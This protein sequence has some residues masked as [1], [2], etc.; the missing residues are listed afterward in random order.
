[1]IIYTVTSLLKMTMLRNTLFVWASVW[2]FACTILLSACDSQHTETYVVSDASPDLVLINKNHVITSNPERYQ[3]SYNLDGHLMPSDYHS[4]LS[5]Y[6][7]YDLKVLVKKGDWVEKG[8]PMMTMQA[9]LPI[10]E[11]QYRYYDNIGIE[12]V[13]SHHS[14]STTTS[15]SLVPSYPKDAQSEN[16]ESVVS[17]IENEVEDVADA[18]SEISEDILVES[19][20]AN[21]DS[22]NAQA[23]SDAK[24][25][26]NLSDDD[27]LRSKKDE[28]DNKDKANDTNEN[29]LSDDNTHYELRPDAPRSIPSDALVNDGMND[30]HAEPNRHNDDSSIDS[31]KTN[32]PQ[33]V[34]TTLTFYAPHDGQVF[35]LADG[36]ARQGGNVPKDARLAMIGDPSTVQL[37][38]KLPISAEKNLSIGQ[39]VTFTIRSLADPIDS[40]AGKFGGQISK[41]TTDKDPSTGHPW[42]WIEAPILARENSEALSVGMPARLSIDYGQINLGVRLPKDAIFQTDLSSLDNQHTRPVSPIEG[43][44]WVIGYDRRLHYTPVQV[45]EY[46][47]KTDRYL[48]AGINNDSLV[49]ELNLPINSD[50]RQVKVD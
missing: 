19:G 24:H 49:V 13:S 33:S 6:R 9:R 30:G 36:L 2:L 45:V 22:P 43:F 41:I 11:A 16:N 17:N 31:L 38:G 21:D 26:Q 44:V 29:K 1:M 46:F 15:K 35:Y 40:S 50:G 4:V 25:P 48:V 7:G 37:V 10:A 28:N 27:N 12:I 18:V 39:A 8:Q 20:L 3:P 23:D 47:P 42:V 32:R 34:L 5:P 14:A